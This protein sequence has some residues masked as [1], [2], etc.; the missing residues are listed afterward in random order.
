MAYLLIRRYSEIKGCFEEVFF[1]PCV[2][3]HVSLCIRESR[4]KCLYICLKLECSATFKAVGLQF[5]YCYHKLKIAGLIC[6][7]SEVV[8]APSSTLF[9]WKSYRTS[10]FLV[11]GHQQYC[12]YLFLFGP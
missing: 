9:K 3:S 7:C 2:I 1:Y 5:K 6:T 10:L 12:F 8:F 4:L 11:F